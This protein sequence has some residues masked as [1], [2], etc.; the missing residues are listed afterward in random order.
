M[1]KR[2][3]IEMANDFCKRLNDGNHKEL[4][5]RLEGVRNGYICGIVT[6]REELEVMRGCLYAA[7][8]IDL[9]R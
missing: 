2:W 9:N 8:T 5:A 6:E 1:N 3:V 7:E 4:L